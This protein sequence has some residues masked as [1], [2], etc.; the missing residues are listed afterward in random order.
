M[1]SIT[2]D[3]QCIHLNYSLVV[4]ICTALH[5]TPLLLLF[6]ILKR[7]SDP[8]DAML[9]HFSHQMIE[10][11]RANKGPLKAMGGKDSSNAMRVNSVDVDANNWAVRALTDRKGTPK[12]VRLMCE[13]RRDV[14]AESVI[15]TEVDTT[16][17]S[18][19]AAAATTTT[20]TTT[21]TSTTTTTA[22]TEAV[23]PASRLCYKWEASGVVTASLA[24][25]TSREAHAFN[26]VSA[27]DYFAAAPEAAASSPGSRSEASLDLSHISRPVLSA[28]ALCSI[29]FC[30]FS[31]VCRL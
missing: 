14:Y 31:D 15:G 10:A 9:R 18:A 24:S 28:P 25:K 13:Q 6:R 5:S 11:H 16:T 30:M 26:Q 27:E 3:C 23:H 21:T 22:A 19:A 20:T 7:F 17:T 2:K 12:T 29:F 1:H 8:S 4:E